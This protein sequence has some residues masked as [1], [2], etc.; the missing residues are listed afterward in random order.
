M[1]YTHNHNQIFEMLHQL[2]NRYQYITVQYTSI[3]HS[4][5]SNHTRKSHASTNAEKTYTYIK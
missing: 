2:H 4:T 3:K 1:T 5:L